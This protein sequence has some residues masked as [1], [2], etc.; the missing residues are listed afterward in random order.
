MSSREYHEA[1]HVKWVAH[2]EY[3]TAPSRSQQFGNAVHGLTGRSAVYFKQD[4]VWR[5]ASLDGIA[6]THRRLARGITCPSATCYDQGWSQTA[7]P[8]CNRMIQARP[9]YW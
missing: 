4:G 7:P 1:K 3:V 6:L 2:Q 8:Q 9:Q 5:D